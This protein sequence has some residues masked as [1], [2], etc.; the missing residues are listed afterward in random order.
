MQPPEPPPGMHPWQVPI[1]PIVKTKH[2]RTAKRW[3]RRHAYLQNLM[4]TW[5]VLHSDPELARADEEL[6]QADDELMTADIVNSCRTAKC[7]HRRFREYWIK[8]LTGYDPEC[9]ISDEEL[10]RQDEWVEDMSW[11][12]EASDQV[13]QMG[14]ER[15]SW[16]FVQPEQLEDERRGRAI[17]ELIEAVPHFVRVLNSKNFTN[18]HQNLIGIRLNN[19]LVSPRGSVCTI[20]EPLYD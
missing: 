6:H 8:G 11:N 9:A 3:R 1:Y 16:E 5:I 18:L 20:L 2:F 4:K 10:D 15:R 14:A 13:V 17:A 7:W 19:L 12:D